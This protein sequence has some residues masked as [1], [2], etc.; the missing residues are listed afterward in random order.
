VTFGTSN[1]KSIF[2]NSTFEILPPIKNLDTMLNFSYQQPSKEN[3]VNLSLYNPT[4]AGKKISARIDVPLEKPILRKMSD[5][6]LTILRFQ[7][8]LT[9]VFPPYSLQGTEFQVTISTAFR[10]ETR[11][12]T[13]GGMLSSYIGDFLEFLLNPLISAC[14]SAMVP[15][16]NGADARRPPYVYYQPQEKLMYFVVPA[17]YQQSVNIFVNRGIYKFISGFPFQKIDDDNYMLRYY[18]PDNSILYSPPVQTTVNKYPK[19]QIAGEAINIP[20]EYPSDY[21]F[22][23]LQSVI[24]TSNLPVRQEILPQS[25]QQDVFNP[26]N[27]LSYI[28]TLPILIDSRPDV[29]QFGLQN[30]SLIYFPTGEFRW[31]DLLSD[32]PLDR[33]S[34]E[35][36]WQS[37]D[38]QIHELYLDPGESVSLKLYFRS[39]Y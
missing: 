7:C 22:N 26:S 28:S 32:G 18:A 39:L 37:S 10:S 30:S 31:I 38:Q 5:Y 4:D 21:R 14:H 23:Q 17:E 11:S 29:N 24:V 27:P 3:V 35:F 19:W 6:K 9:T 13:G 34:F 2:D 16:I 15:Y 12:S 33:L 8:P 36:L 1:C 25:T 20:Q